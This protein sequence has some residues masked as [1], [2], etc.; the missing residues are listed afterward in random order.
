M[1]LEQTSNLWNQAE[2]IIMDE[3]RASTAIC[4]A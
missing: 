2:D 3:P 1:S 4:Q